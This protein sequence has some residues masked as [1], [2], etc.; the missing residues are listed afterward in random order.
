MDPDYT[1][2]SF[3]DMHAQRVSELQGRYVGIFDT[4]ENS[5]T[6]PGSCKAICV[7]DNRYPSITGAAKAMGISVSRLQAKIR[8]GEVK[9][10]LDGQGK[11]P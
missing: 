7:G 6:Y 4:K 9:A 10:T 2:Q 1:P 5:P 11:T 8:R 3:R